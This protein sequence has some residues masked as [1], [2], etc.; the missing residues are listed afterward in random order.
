MGFGGRWGNDPIW[1]PDAL[2]RDSRLGNAGLDGVLV[3]LAG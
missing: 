3:A 1:Q 2:M